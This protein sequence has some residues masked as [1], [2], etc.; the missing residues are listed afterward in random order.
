MTGYSLCN[1]LF[2]IFHIHHSIFAAG[3][4]A[5]N[6]LGF[7]VSQTMCEIGNR[8]ISA[9]G[10]QRK[11][12]LLNEM[13]TDIVSKDIERRL[14]FA[15]FNSYST[16]NNANKYDYWENHQL[17]L[18]DKSTFTCKATTSAQG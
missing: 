14:I 6:V 4:G 9:N 17:F 15:N 3:S 13:S 8:V 2:I 7:E 5:D 1:V 18:V 12:S 10:F 16:I 11:I